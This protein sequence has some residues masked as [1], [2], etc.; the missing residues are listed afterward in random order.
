[1]NDIKSRIAKLDTLI[2]Q[3][4]ELVLSRK[5]RKEQVM[6][7]LEDILCEIQHLVSII[8]HV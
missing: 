4:R 5:H 1:M 3:L 2:P 7:L 8:Q 6:I